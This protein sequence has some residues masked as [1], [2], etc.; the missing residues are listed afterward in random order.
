MSNPILLVEDELYLHHLVTQSLKREGIEVVCAHSGDEAL[1]MSRER[2]EGFSVLLADIC[3][4]PPLHDGVELA[5]KLRDENPRL[6]VLYL[7][8]SP[9]SPVVQ[10][11]LEAGKASFLWKP[12]ALKTLSREIRLLQQQAD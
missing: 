8:G 3:L 6:K 9:P 4:E 12:F 1:R 11:E 2:D 10:Q 5:K 7:S